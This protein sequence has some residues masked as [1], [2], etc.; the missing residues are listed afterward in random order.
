MGLFAHL[1]ITGKYTGKI[2]KLRVSRRRAIKFLQKEI[3]DVRSCCDGKDYVCDIRPAGTE[4]VAIID[5]DAEDL[6]CSV[7]GLP[8]F[9]EQRPQHFLAAADGEHCPTAA[10]IRTGTDGAV[11]VT[12]TARRQMGIVEYREGRSLKSLYKKSRAPLVDAPE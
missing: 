5:A 1:V 9:P 6:V 4:P 10:E 3:V 8:F 2:T 11:T 7:C 12:F